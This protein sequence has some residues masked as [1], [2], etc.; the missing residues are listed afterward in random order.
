MS[1]I[2]RH[3]QNRCYNVLCR[4]GSNCNYNIDYIRP[5][6]FIKIMG[7]FLKPTHEP[8]TYIMAREEDDKFVNLLL[9]L[10]DRR[11]IITLAIEL[12]ENKICNEGNIDYDLIAKYLPSGFIRDGY[13]VI[14]VVYIDYIIK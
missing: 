9:T 10:T 12:D 13:F 5:I 2:H 1:I 14:D 7:E 3:E 8:D 4:G 6:K 11:N